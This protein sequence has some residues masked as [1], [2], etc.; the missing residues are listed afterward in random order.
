MIGYY[1]PKIQIETAIF[2]KN[3]AKHEI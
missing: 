3:K 2:A 1:P